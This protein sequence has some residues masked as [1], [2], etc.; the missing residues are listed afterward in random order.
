MIRIK[1]ICISFNNNIYKSSVKNNY[2]ICV[3]FFGK[4][5]RSENTVEYCKQGN[6]IFW[7][8]MTL[9]IEYYLDFIKIFDESIIK[10]YLHYENEIESISNTDIKIYEIVE[11]HFRLQTKFKSIRNNYNYLSFKNYVSLK[12]SFKPL[13]S[14]FLAKFADNCILSLEFTFSNVKLVSHNEITSSIDQLLKDKPLLNNKVMKNLLATFS[15]NLYIHVK[16]DEIR[17]KNVPVIQCYFKISIKEDSKYSNVF[18]L[19]ETLKIDQSFFFIINKKDFFTEKLEISILKKSNLEFLINDKLIGYLSFPLELIIKY[20]EN[21]II[22]EWLNLTSI[23]ELCDFK[24]K[25]TISLKTKNNSIFPPEFINNGLIPAKEKFK[26]SKLVLKIICINIIFI[27]MFQKFYF[28]EDHCVDESIKDKLTFLYLLFNSY[29]IN[30]QIVRPIQVNC[31]I[32]LNFLNQTIKEQRFFSVNQNTQSKYEYIDFGKNLHFELKIPFNLNS[33]NFMILLSF[34]CDCFKKK[35]VTEFEYVLDSVNRKDDFFKSGMI[36]FN[37]FEKSAN[38]K[39]TVGLTLIEIETIRSTNN[40]FEKRDSLITPMMLQGVGIKKCEYIVCMVLHSINKIPL[41]IKN[42]LIVRCRFENLLSERS[43]EYEED[44]FIPILNQFYNEFFPVLLV[45]FSWINQLFKINLMNLIDNFILKLSKIYESL[46][47]INFLFIDNDSLINLIRNLYNFI[48]EFQNLLPDRRK[49][50]NVDNEF[51]IRLESTLLDFCKN[52]KDDLRCIIHFANKIKNHS[53]VLKQNLHCQLESILENIKCTLLNIRDVEV[54][55]NFPNLLIEIYDPSVIKKDDYS[56]PLYCTKIP[57]HKIFYNT[58][59]NN[60]SGEWANK[61]KIYNLNCSG[62]IQEKNNLLNLF[63]CTLLLGAEVSIFENTNEFFLFCKKKSI[64]F[65]KKTELLKN[66]SKLLKFPVK[67]SY[68]LNFVNN[69]EVN[70]VNGIKVKNFNQIFQTNCFSEPVLER[71]ISVNYFKWQKNDYEVL[72]EIQSI[73]NK[74]NKNNNNRIKAESFDLI[75][76]TKCYFYYS[77]I[78]GHFKKFKRFMLNEDWYP[79]IYNGD[80]YWEYSNNLNQEIWHENLMRDN[81]TKFYFRRCK[82]LRRIESYN[83]SIYLKAFSP[84]NKLYRQVNNY[85]NK[86]SA[87]Y[88][89]YSNNPLSKNSNTKSIENLFKLSENNLKYIL[90]GYIGTAKLLSSILIYYPKNIIINL[91]NETNVNYS[92]SFF[93]LK[94]YFLS[95]T[96]VF[97]SKNISDKLEL[98]FLN[99]N[100]IWDEVIKFEFQGTQHA[101]ELMTDNLLFLFIE[102]KFHYCDM[103]TNIEYL[104]GTGKVYINYRE[105]KSKQFNFSNKISLHLDDNVENKKRKESAIVLMDFYFVKSKEDS[106]NIDFYNKLNADRLGNDFRVIHILN[107]GIRF[108]D[109]FFKKYLKSTGK[110]RKLK[111]SL[112]IEDSNLAISRKIQVIFIFKNN[113]HKSNL[114]IVKNYALIDTNNNEC[115]NNFEEIKFFDSNY[116]ALSTKVDIFLSIYQSN[117]VCKNEISKNE[118]ITFGYAQ[119]NEID[120][121]LNRPYNNRFIFEN[122]LNKITEKRYKSAKFLNLIQNIKKNDLSLYFKNDTIDNELDFWNRYNESIKMLK[123]NYKLHEKID[124]LFLFNILFREFENNFNS[125]SSRSIKIYN[126]E[127]ARKSMSENYDMLNLSDLDYCQ[128]TTKDL[129]KVNKLIIGEL[130]LKPSSFIIS[131][132]SQIVSKTKNNQQLINNFKEYFYNL[133]C[134]CI[135]RLYI[136]KAYNIQFNFIYNNVYNLVLNPYIQVICKGSNSTSDI[137]LNSK[138]FIVEDKENPEFGEYFEFKVNIPEHTVL[139]IRILNKNLNIMKA[140]CEDELIGFTEIN[141]EDRLTNSNR[142]TCGIPCIYVN[143]N[144]DL[145]NMLHLKQSYKDIYEKNKKKLSLLKWRDV[146]KPSEILQKICNITYEELKIYEK[147]LIAI[148]KNETIALDDF[149]LDNLNKLY[150]YTTNIFEQFC[151]NIL[152]TRFSLAKEHIETRTLHNKEKSHIA[153][154][155]HMWLDILPLGTNESNNLFSHITPINIE[156]RKPIEMELRCII[157]DV[158][159]L[160]YKSE[161]SNQTRNIYV[162]GWISGQENEKDKTD[163]HCRCVKKASFNYR[164]IHKF[165]YLKYEKCIIK[166]NNCTLHDF[167]F[168]PKNIL[169]QDSYILKSNDSNIRSYNQKDKLKPKLI[170]QIMDSDILDIQSRVIGELEL[171]LNQVIEPLRNEPKMLNY[172]IFNLKFINMFFSFILNRDLNLKER[173]YIKTNTFDLFEINKIEGWWFCETP[174]DKFDENNK[175]PI[176]CIR[177]SL[178]VLSSQDSKLKPNLKLNEPYRE[179]LFQNVLFDQIFKLIAFFKRLI[180][181]N[182]PELPRY[183]CYIAVILFIFLCIFALPEAIVNRVITKLF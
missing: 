49:Y 75:W 63:T 44:P 53:H 50:E 173:N 65:F 134:C 82:W 27:E 169:S 12:F 142:T 95:M 3:E 104:I 7:N 96:K 115:K 17:T 92:S 16:F 172:S 176:C 178:E 60:Y 23:L 91:L 138:S 22:N 158:V 99:K 35:F 144:E 114:K 66:E 130:K 105:T 21:G 182:N 55:L 183:I 141:L 157:W 133:P 146:E 181:T 71:K 83:Q 88:F 150:F 61:L 10:I 70:A 1:P 102:L 69:S 9:A 87:R 131:P 163:T 28:N 78:D 64:V 140:R 72:Y 40:N 148:I 68:L 36:A 93:S 37:L 48:I 128:L 8:E 39:L 127:N 86:I 32:I 74:K 151:L 56:H 20:T 11:K 38:K 30:K 6:I 153:G 106:K 155:I 162:K 45:S 120:V 119:I 81:L 52:S 13:C 43:F 124:S 159:F 137:K 101:T 57:C 89:C 42:K 59:Q 4:K 170:I 41:E 135:V 5:L 103:N 117:K 149:N 51:D 34:S 113:V 85:H 121:F 167:S 14:K 77:S 179:P 147:D 129:R 143:V 46:K 175:Q 126:Y 15:N 62:N 107:Y 73:I 165:N 31:E 94:I 122:S 164:F 90:N 18:K 177:M 125:I 25:A 54:N 145:N 161:F 116:Q 58:E 97:I 111:N 100:P 98:S 76:K 152:N 156:L 47:P 139:Q 110:L 2:F 67:S 79:E 24:I 123:S 108:S 84:I 168:S 26:N 132:D 180:Y 171:D 166:N 154:K 112:N 136:I 174:I 19:T 109:F 33:I 80:K 160:S 29:R 118:I